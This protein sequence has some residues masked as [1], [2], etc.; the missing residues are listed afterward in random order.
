VAQSTLQGV[1]DQYTDEVLKVRTAQSQAVVDFF[2]SQVTDQA[3]TLA[4]ADARVAQYSAAQRP[5]KTATDLTLVALQRADDLARQ[6]YEGLLLELDQAKLD[7]SAASGAGGTGLRLIDP[8]TLPPA[9]VGRM[10]TL[11]R[12]G[13]ASLAAGLLIMLFCVLA[14]TAADTSVHSPE[15][16]RRALGLR[17]VGAIPRLRQANP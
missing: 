17:L 6:R 3:K 7:Q 13:L 12:T 11:V 14:L 9:Q 16:V 5:S 15:D 1:I 2:Q 4:A 8:P 10:G